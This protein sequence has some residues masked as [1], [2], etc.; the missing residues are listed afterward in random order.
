MLVEQ[1]Q[2]ELGGAAF[3]QRADAFEDIV[4]RGVNRQR[5]LQ[6]EQKANEQQ[7][8]GAARQDSTR[9][10]MARPGGHGYSNPETL[11]PFQ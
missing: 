1:S 8:A 11:T 4:I 9:L 2:S 3:G 10:R 6:E 7:K 5:S